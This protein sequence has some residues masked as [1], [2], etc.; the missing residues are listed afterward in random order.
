MQHYYFCS[1]CWL[2]GVINNDRPKKCTHVQ[3]PAIFNNTQCNKNN[4]KKNT[5]PEGWSRGAFDLCVFKRIPTYTAL[6]HLTIQ[7]KLDTH[8][9]G[10]NVYTLQCSTLDGHHP[11][12]LNFFLFSLIACNYRSVNALDCVRFGPLI[13]VRTPCST[14]LDEWWNIR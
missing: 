13:V 5:I 6:I 2:S 7:P 12:F 4:L 9:Y 8:I 14:R 3:E 10:Y 11:R 1:L